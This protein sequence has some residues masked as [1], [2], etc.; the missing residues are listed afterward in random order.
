MSTSNE[1]IVVYMYPTHGAHARIGVSVR[2][3]V[4][5]MTLRSQLTD[6]L[7]RFDFRQYRP[8]LPKSL[9]VH[10][11][12]ETLGPDPTSIP[13]SIPRRSPTAHHRARAHQSCRW[14]DRATTVP[15]VDAARRCPRRCPWQLPPLLRPPSSSSFCHG[16]AIAAA[17]ADGGRRHRPMQTTPPRRLQ[18]LK[19]CQPT[20]W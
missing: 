11:R 9:A 13:T 19:A 8:S 5:V 17:R 1:S 20:R 10:W 7:Y 16:L 18:A 3:N 2:T 12:S 4:A 15:H 14:G 6:R